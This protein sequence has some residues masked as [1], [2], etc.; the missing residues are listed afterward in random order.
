MKLLGPQDF[1]WWST[2]VRNE[3]LLAAACGH[4]VSI[5][6][7]PTHEVG[8]VVACGNGEI[9]WQEQHN[10][11]HGTIVS[12]DEDETIVKILGPVLT[13]Y[14][15]QTP[16]PQMMATIN[17]NGKIFPEKNPAKDKPVLGDVTYNQTG[18]FKVYV[19]VGKPFDNNRFPFIPAPGKKFAFSWGSFTNEG[20]IDITR[21]NYNIHH[22]EFT[23]NELSIW[24]TENLFTAPPVPELGFSEAVTATPV[25]KEYTAEK[26][27]W[28][29]RNA[30]TY[31]N[32]LPGKT[33]MLA[34][35]IADAP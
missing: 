19:N 7:K 33:Q 21:P 8:L 18:E 1:S 27:V 5:P 4:M 6:P 22:V 29:F 17:P 24:Y 11:P 15:L 14:E 12:T 34:I 25:L 30:A 26:C 9:G 31:L 13:S 32:T 2:M 20:S 28:R 23:N 10:G 35:G 16:A 3:H